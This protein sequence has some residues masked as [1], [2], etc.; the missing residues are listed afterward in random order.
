MTHKMARIAILSLA[1]V[2]MVAAV[3]GCGLFGG[4]EEVVEEVVEEPTPDLAATIQAAIVASRPTETPTPPPTDPPTPDIQ[5]TINAALTATQ[6]AMAPTDVPP[7]E[8]PVVAATNTPAPTDTPQPTPTRQAS[9]PVS[10]P[11]AVI[12]GLVTRNNQKVEAGTTVI[13]KPQGGGD[14]VT[15]VTDGNGNY[16]LET[17]NFGVIYDLYVGATDSTV[18]SNATAKGILQVKNLVIN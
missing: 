14:P 6:I 15:A 9:N 3:A 10:G 2:L 7:T 11:P 18:D 8:V 4:G 5:A 12:V 16:K 1:A 13:G 17:T